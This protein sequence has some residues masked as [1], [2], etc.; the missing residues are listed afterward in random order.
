MHNKSTR[1]NDLGLHMTKGISFWRRTPPA[2][3]PVCLGLLGLG[4]AW[5]KAVE[6][7]GVPWMIGE[8]IALS[9]AVLLLFCWVSYAAKLIKRA[10][11]VLNDLEIG[12]ARG[13]VSAGSMSGLALA[14]VL[15]PYSTQSATVVL[16]GSVVFHDIYFLCVM[17][18]L[19]RHERWLAEVNPVLLLPF[20]GIIV[21]GLSAPQLGFTWFS[22][23]ILFGTLPFA[24]AIVVLTFWN[25][26]MRG[27]QPPL[28]PAF[29]ILLA[30]ISIYGLIS[31]EL[32][33]DGAFQFWWLVSI[34]CF[35]I[36][37]LV[38]PWMAKG[39]WN[40]G[41]GAFTFPTAAFASLQMT[42]ISL[43]YGTSANLFAVASLL[44]ATIVIPF[45]AFKTFRA[46]GK[47]VLAE[48]TKAAIA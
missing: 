44:L 8:V 10:S 30:P 15:L 2:L 13:A 46:W 7:W 42:A 47:G 11:V 20:V 27:V 45:I 41:W 34:F 12:P 3:F 43:G 23:A 40:P 37:T 6:I 19:S 5:R 28:R 21:A 4:L 48:K 32:G 26:G 25:M 35:T 18:I 39:G 1:N 9:S 17:Y 31:A 16:W 22:I 24:F 33:W 38:S 36:L 14:A 29:A